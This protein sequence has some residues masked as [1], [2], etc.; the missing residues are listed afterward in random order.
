M[1]VKHS[2]TFYFSFC[3]LVITLG[4]CSFFG[5]SGEDE[6][7]KPLARVY[8]RYL[9]ESD[10]EDILPNES[11]SSADS[12]AFIQNYINVWAKSQLMLYKA[13][14]NLNEDQKAFDEQILK[15][16]NDLLKFA[17]QEEFLRQNL[18]TSITPQEIASYY[19]D[20]QDNFLLR[21]NIV[22]A[23]YVIIG[24]NAPKLKEAKKWFGSEEPEDVENLRNYSLKYARA[25]YEDS[26]WVSFDQ[27]ITKVPGLEGDL[28]QK[29]YLTQNNLSEF[30]D[31]VKVSLLKI[32]DFKLKGEKAPLSYVQDLIKNILMNKKKLQLLAN[33]EKNLLEDALKRK[34]FETY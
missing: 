1:K 24:S 32:N 16:R 13:E 12:L 9:Y 23:S 31:S 11:I 25:F 22:K 4:G 10:L 26:V 7:G 18:D 34:E 30:S 27:I 8:D 33:L 19:E 29:Q 15:Y 6:K 5:N 28:N 20:A 17:Y 14:Y 2:F 3:V 21:E